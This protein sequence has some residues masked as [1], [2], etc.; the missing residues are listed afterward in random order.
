MSTLSSLNRTREQ[1]NLTPQRLHHCI[2]SHNH[3][4]AL[5]RVIAVEQS[6]HPPRLRQVD[7][8]GRLLLVVRILLHKRGRLV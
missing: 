1:V 2:P 8:G 6:G 5:V 3:T 4:L 7:Q